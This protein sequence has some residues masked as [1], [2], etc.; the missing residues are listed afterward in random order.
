MDTGGTRHPLSTDPAQAN[1]K[2][3]EHDN[4]DLENGV[5]FRT[6]NDQ[7]LVKAPPNSS[8]RKKMD[9]LNDS[10][11]SRRVNTQMSA[12]DEAHEFFTKV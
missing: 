3:G 5:E 4:Q 7:V 6:E 1:E 10:C 8:R 2:A 11:S 12:K 9:E